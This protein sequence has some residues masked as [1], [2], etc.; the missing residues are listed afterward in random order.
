MIG[1]LNSEYLLYTL[2][3]QLIAVAIKHHFELCV[4]DARSLKISFRVIP[5]FLKKSKIFLNL[6]LQSS[7]YVRIVL[8]MLF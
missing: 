5:L 1:I 8:W 4:H 3:V 7:I 6:D 2:A